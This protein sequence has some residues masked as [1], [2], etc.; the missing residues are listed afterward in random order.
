MTD[1]VLQLVFLRI[2][3]IGYRV[4]VGLPDQSDDGGK[5]DDPSHSQM[6]ICSLTEQAIQ[7]V[8]LQ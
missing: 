5:Q 8:P 6:A 7:L 4:S 2:V 3:H 1:P